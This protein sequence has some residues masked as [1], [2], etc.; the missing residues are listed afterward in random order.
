MLSMAGPTVAGE[1]RHDYLWLE[2]PYSPHSILEKYRSRPTP[3]SLLQGAGVA[4]VVGASEVLSRT[5][6]AARRQELSGT[7]QAQTQSQL[8]TDEILSAL[9]PRKR[10]IRRLPSQPPPHQSQQGGVLIIWMSPDDEQPLVSRE[11]H[12]SPIDHL[13]ATGSG[14]IERR[15]SWGSGLL[16]NQGQGPEDR[17]QR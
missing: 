2:S 17:Q 16:G 7:D 13:N 5:F 8:G 14:R 10:Q 12:Q 4:K 15:E 9:A 1:D 3:E 6:Q 11:L